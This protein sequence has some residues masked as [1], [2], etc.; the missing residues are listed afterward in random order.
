MVA[1]LPQVNRKLNP[2]PSHFKGDKRPVEEVSWYEAVEFCDCCPAEIA[3]F[4]RTAIA[5]VWLMSVE[6]LI[7]Y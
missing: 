4:S 6:G 5:Y 3:Y 1:A 7:A 2:E